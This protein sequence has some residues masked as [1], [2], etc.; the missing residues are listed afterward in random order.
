MPINDNGTDIEDRPDGLFCGALGRKMHVLKYRFAL[1]SNPNP[2]EKVPSYDELCQFLIS[3]RTSYKIYETPLPSFS[4]SCFF[5]TWTSTSLGM[6]SYFAAN[7]LFEDPFVGLN[8]VLVMLSLTS[9][10]IKNGYGSGILVGLSFSAFVIFCGGLLTALGFEGTI[11][12]S[13]DS[14]MGVALAIFLLFNEIKG[15]II[16]H[17]QIVFDNVIKDFPGMKKFILELN[18]QSAEHIPLTEK[19]NELFVRL[20]TDATQSF[21]EGKVSLTDHIF[22]N[23]LNPAVGQLRKSPDSIRELLNVYP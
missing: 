4:A 23:L 6:F 19:Q 14:L 7:K 22:L 8:Y 11:S 5:R 12:A 15:K 13:I 3:F 9:T 20:F 18:A 16:E 2:V 10:A 1:A 17:A 21:V